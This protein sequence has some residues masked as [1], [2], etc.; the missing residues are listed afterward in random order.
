MTDAG[1]VVQL[2]PHAGAVGPGLPFGGA[3]RTRQY[4]M[5]RQKND[6]FGEM[7]F[8]IEVNLQSTL[9]VF[10][11]SKLEFRFGMPPFWQF[12]PGLLGG[13]VGCYHCWRYSGGVFAKWQEC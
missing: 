10:P 7:Q 11:W 9:Y 5:L 4:T 2:Q 12:D 13:K 3:R 6:T 1:V 8:R